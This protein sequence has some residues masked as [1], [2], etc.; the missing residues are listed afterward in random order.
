[1]SDATITIFHNPACGTSRNTLALIRNSGDE[2]RVIDSGEFADDVRE[3]ERY[4]TD[5]GIHSVPSVI[6]D[7]KH[8]IQGGQ[9]SDV[10]EQ[11]LRKIAAQ[12]A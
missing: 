11:A 6:I 7:D 10:F 8:L 12:Q 1:M 4:Y 2:P 9:T 3:R 5:R